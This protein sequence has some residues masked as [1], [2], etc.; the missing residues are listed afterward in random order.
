[1][2][3]SLVCADTNLALKLVLHERGSALARAL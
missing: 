2:T 3:N 1:M